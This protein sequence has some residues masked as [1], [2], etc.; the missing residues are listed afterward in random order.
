MYALIHV[1]SALLEEKDVFKFLYGATVTRK[2]IT[3][4]KIFYTNENLNWCLS[5]ALSL[6]LSEIDSKFLSYSSYKGQF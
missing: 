5:L 3:Q 4:I 6:I 1:D 2:I